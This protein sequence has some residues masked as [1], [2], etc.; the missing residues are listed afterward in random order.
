MTLETWQQAMNLMLCPVTKE[1]TLALHVATNEDEVEGKEAKPS[2]G[3]GTVEHL[4]TIPGH[5]QSLKV[6]R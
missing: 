5:V 1:V 2:R 4:D 6:T 3:V